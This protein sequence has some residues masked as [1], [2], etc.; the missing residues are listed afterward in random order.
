MRAYRGLASADQIE[1]DKSA[2][3][4]IADLKDEARDGEPDMPTSR[5][6]ASW[7]MLLLTAR[8]L[9]ELPFE[10]NMWQAQNIWYDTL[11]L[12]RKQ[13]LPDGVGRKIP[14]TWAG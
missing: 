8:T 6:C 7:T 2:L 11:K 4:Y 12:S 14:E 1:L 10:L 9:N 5:A 3:G 13:E